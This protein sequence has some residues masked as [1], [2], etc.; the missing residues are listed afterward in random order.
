[1]RRI[2]SLVPSITELVCDFGLAG[3][4]VGRTGF[5]IHPAEIVKK[6]PKVGGTKDV[7]LAKKSRQVQLRLRRQRQLG[8]AFRR[9]LQVAPGGRG[10]EHQGQ[11]AVRRQE[12]GLSEA[13]DCVPI[14]ISSKLQEL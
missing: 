7:D 10:R 4:P 9:A 12:V 2:V 5:C 13:T 11:I 14:R 6:I 8:A 3:E 1:L